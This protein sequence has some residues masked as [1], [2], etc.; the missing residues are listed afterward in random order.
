MTLRAFGS[1][2]SLRKASEDDRIG[3]ADQGPADPH[4][5]V[6]AEFMSR[7]ERQGYPP[8]KDNAWHS[9]A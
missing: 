4:P 1:R 8:K 5:G 2:V 3:R 6:K 7:E 9:A